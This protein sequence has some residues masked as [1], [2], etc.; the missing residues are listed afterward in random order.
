MI[1]PTVKNS[2]ENKKILKSR[3]YKKVRIP[4]NLKIFHNKIHFSRS[5]KIKIK[6]FQGAKTSIQLQKI[7]KI[8]IL[9]VMIFNK[10]FLLVKTKKINKIHFLN[11]QKI[12]F[13]I[14][15]KNNFKIKIQIKIKWINHFKTKAKK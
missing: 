1:S 6:G 4:K 13:K 3:M 15:K 7:L 2:R 12:M 14:S 8:L 9:K 10:L 5:I 11:Q